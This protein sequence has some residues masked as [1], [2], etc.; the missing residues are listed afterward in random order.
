MQFRNDFLKENVLLCTTLQ[1]S[2]SYYFTKNIP[3]NPFLNS[4]IPLNCCT[5]KKKGL[6][7]CILFPFFLQASP[8][9]DQIGFL[10]GAL[11]EI[12]KRAAS[13]GKL[14]FIYFTA[15]WCM[16]CQWME[17]NTFKDKQLSSYVNHYY[18]PYKVDIDDV[19]G[20]TYKEKYEIVSLP[21]FLIF[22]SKGNL[23]DR[24][25]ESLSASKMLLILQSYNKPQNRTIVRQPIVADS[26][27]PVSTEAYQPSPQRD[28]RYGASDASASRETEY[29]GFDYDEF[30]EEGTSTSSRD[31][32]NQEASYT[33]PEP[34]AN[35][36]GDIRETR[37]ESYDYNPPPK[38]KI[39][40]ASKVE[41]PPKR[42]YTVQI[43]A[44]AN[45]SS[46]QRESKKIK[47]RFSQDVF[48]FTSRSGEKTIY[49]MAI[50]AFAT[51]DA[52]ISFL[53]E[54]KRHSVDG[55]VKRLSDF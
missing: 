41:S 32:N 8:P 5:M 1:K 33:N 23:L 50:G 37:P 4:F 26:Y 18:L 52:A 24:F 53:N 31:R 11:S 7:F 12:E 16:P 54:L 44:Y 38:H 9:A 21:S 19:E 46:V 39:P 15:D 36:P 10:S 45:Q 6:F 25:E 27:A 17:K 2:S 47:A 29:G 13:E 49:K 30:Q 20:S 14:Y 40:A 51:K 34:I 28:V 48:I 55:F 43:G 22:D 3:G 35:V 42:G